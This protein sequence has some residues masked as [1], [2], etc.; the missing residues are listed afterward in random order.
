LRHRTRLALVRLAEQKGLQLIV[1]DLCFDLTREKTVLR[2]RKGH[3]VYLQHM[4]ENFDYYVDSVIPI[5]TDDSLLVDMSGPRYHRLKGFGEIPFLFPTH[6]EPYTTTAEYLD[7]AN[8]REGETVLDLGAYAGL[9]S[10]IFARLVG[11]SG[12]V[13]ALEADPVNHRC[14]AIN[15]EMAS[16][17]MALNNIL[18]LHRAVWSHSDG[19]LFSSEGAMGSSAVTVTGGNR[20]NEIL[21]PSTR[22]DELFDELK[23]KRVDFVKIDIEGCEVTVLE[24]SAKFLRTMGAR[25]IVE[26]HM[27]DGVLNADRCGQILKSAGYSVNIRSKTGESEAL[28]EARP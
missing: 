20:G 3:A 10:I 1:R 19:L 7:F 8:L 23:L 26:P 27:V 28:I 12:K 15:I 21:I 14:A 24:A 2:I 6:T 4:I 16:H 22:L 9:T 13:I 25:L 5:A 18:L 17:V 11:R